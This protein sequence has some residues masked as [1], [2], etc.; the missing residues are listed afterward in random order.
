MISIDTVRKS[1]VS[2]RTNGAIINSA[3]SS[4]IEAMGSPEEEDE[5]EDMV[6]DQQ[7]HENADTG[8][9]SHAPAGIE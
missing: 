7:N 5:R 2:K 1:A 6:T 8:D 9:K 4:A 3:I